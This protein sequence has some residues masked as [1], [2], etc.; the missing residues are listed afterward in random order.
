MK[1]KGKKY[2]Q[3]IYEKTYVCYFCNRCGVIIHENEWEG[4]KHSKC[5]YFL[6]KR[7]IREKAEKSALGIIN[8]K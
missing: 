4:D 6:S 1:N 7:E 8:K 3:K 2:I 5:D